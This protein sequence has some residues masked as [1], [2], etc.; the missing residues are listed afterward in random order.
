MADFNPVSFSPMKVYY[1][2]SRGNPLMFLFVVLLILALIPILG[3][4][5]L[6][7]MGA[8]LIAWTVLTLRRSFL[9][10]RKSQVKVENPVVVIDKDGREISIESRS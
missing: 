10:S 8:S 5:L 1:A 9:S 2:S 4:F 7:A 3:G 6:F